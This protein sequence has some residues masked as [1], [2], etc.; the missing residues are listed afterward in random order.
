MQPADASKQCGLTRAGGPEQRN[1]FTRSN[2]ETDLIER[3]LRAA[4]LP[5]ALA[6]LGDLEVDW[7]SIGH[8]A[9]CGA[10]S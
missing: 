10:T 7:A 8:G 9:E 4:T 3:R 1:H 5:E 2:R 6:E